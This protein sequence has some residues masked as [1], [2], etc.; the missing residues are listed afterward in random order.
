MKQ[1]IFLALALFCLTSSA[2]ATDY[3]LTLYADGCDSPNTFTC[4]AGQQFS[5]SANPMEHRHFVKWNDG[6]TDNPRLVTLN[7]NITYTAI[8]ANDHEG[9]CGDNLF[10]Q[11]TNNTLTLRG[12][13]AMYDYTS[14]TMPWIWLRDSISQI[15]IPSSVTEI[16]EQ[17]FSNC[18]GV[19][20]V[21][22][23]AV[24]PPVCA[25]DAFN[26]MGQ[27]TTN[28]HVLAQ[29]VD[30]YKVALGWRFFFNILGDYEK[31]ALEDVL[32]N[33]QTTSKF[34]HTGQLYIL[35]DGM[36][37]TIQGIEIK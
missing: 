31:T 37:Y 23:A 26:G 17:A 11:Y 2:W 12:T 35:R 29:S 18:T 34:F 10:W 24:T 19:K 32:L 9:K 33:N 5:I 1:T 14:S 36:T 21:Y 7:Q 27:F 25:D 16:G 22:S 3:T 13:G 28:L 30:M 15:I 8:F 20:D 6:N 4:N